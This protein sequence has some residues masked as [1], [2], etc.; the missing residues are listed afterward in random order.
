MDNCPQFNLFHLQFRS[1][2]QHQSHSIFTFSG[3][4]VLSICWVV[5]SHCYSTP[6]TAAPVDSIQ[7]SKLSQRTSFSSRPPYSPSLTPHIFLP[8]LTPPH[9]TH[10]TCSQTLKNF[11][12]FVSF[13]GTRDDNLL[14]NLKYDCHHPKNYE[15]VSI[16]KVLNFVKFVFR[17]R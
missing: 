7:F 16:K 10:K 9:M 4:R 17:D 6:L 8:S 11:H 3:I 13:N 14:I 1:E 5:L 15:V 2:S 12:V